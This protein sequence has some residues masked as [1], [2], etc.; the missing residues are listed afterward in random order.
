MLELALGHLQ[1]SPQQFWSMT[2]R[3]WSA[4]VRGYKRKHGIEDGADGGTMTR[5]ELADLMERF[6]DQAVAS[7]ID[8]VEA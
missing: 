3:E 5:A 1:L 7:P 2:L 6:P 8:A 4:A